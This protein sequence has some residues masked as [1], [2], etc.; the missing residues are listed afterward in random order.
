MT[1]V[2]VSFALIVLAAAGL[3]FVTGKLPEFDYSP[4]GKNLRKVVMTVQ[5][6]KQH[7]EVMYSIGAGFSKPE[8]VKGKHQWRKT[9]YVETGVIIYVT[10]TQYVNKSL[11]CFIQ[12]ADRPEW[13]A[14]DTRGTAG[15]VVCR[16]VVS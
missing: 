16:T 15:G 10:S 14:T 3:L 5:M 1:K 11:T 6:E 13:A 8:T 4:G 2:K 7:V 12:I 9:V